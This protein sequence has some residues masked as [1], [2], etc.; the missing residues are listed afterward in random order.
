LV[1]ETDASESIAEAA[2]GVG[3]ATE[4]ERFMREVLGRLDQAHI[5]VEELE[6][7]LVSTGKLPGSN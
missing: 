4:T 1:V 3:P 6:R 2:T 5:K 7:A